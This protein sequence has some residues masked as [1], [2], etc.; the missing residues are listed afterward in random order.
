MAN[1]NPQNKFQ[2]GNKQASKKLGQPHFMSRDIRTLIR[3]AAEE[4]GFIER[5]PVLD[6]A[7]K[8]TGRY[9]QKYGKVGE[10]KLIP[11]DVNTKVEEKTVVRYETVEE[12]RAAMI[13]KG[14]SPA[15]LAALEAPPFDTMHRATLRKMRGIQ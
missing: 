12:R 8:P 2:K 9:E 14:W 7:G 13:A 6:E 3:E 5:V 10:G 11:F 4:V 1:P 15:T